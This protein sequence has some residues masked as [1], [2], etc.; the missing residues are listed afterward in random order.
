[1]VFLASGKNGTNKENLS[2]N[3]G[4]IPLFNPASPFCK[5]LRTD[6]SRLHHASSNC[7][8]NSL[9][10]SCWFKCITCD[11]SLKMSDPKLDVADRKSTRLNS[12]HVSIS[13][14]VFCLKKKKNYSNND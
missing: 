14:A 2:K 11:K 9:G 7:E 12:S 10:F 13:Y 4:L 8:V 3:S 5:A 1:M 6:D